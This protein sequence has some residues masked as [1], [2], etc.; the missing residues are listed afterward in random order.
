MNRFIIIAFLSLMALL[1]SAGC[2]GL[3]PVQN[4]PGDQPAGTQYPTVY[5]P[6][7]GEPVPQEAVNSQTNSPSAGGISAIS[8]M[9]IW[10]EPLDLG[11][12]HN[13]DGLIVKYR[14]YDANN[15]PV[16]FEGTSI[17]M[18][19][20]IHTPDTNRQRLKITPRQIYRGS[21][22]I[23]RSLPEEDY[24]LRGIWI[25]YTELTLSDQDRGIGSIHA[26]ANLPTGV[27]FE[28]EE[29]YIWPVI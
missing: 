20:T 2:T 28:A 21:S 5:E 11:G 12:F 13:L 17:S 24:P 23:T 14:F 29:R 4:D 19:I 27:V 1:I 26:R 6:Q 18:Q 22:T 15:R 3:L 10:A 9:V 7:L 25:P 8:R 16:S